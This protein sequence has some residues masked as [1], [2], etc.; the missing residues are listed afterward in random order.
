MHGRRN[1]A[2]VLARGEEVTDDFGRRPGGLIPPG[3]FGVPAPPAPTA[4]ELEQWDTL[5]SVTTTEGLCGEAA[6]DLEAPLRICAPHLG[7][8]VSL[9]LKQLR[10]AASDGHE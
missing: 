4:E 10:K 7:L 1:L 2:E 9:A 5:C 8:A 6:V 3:L